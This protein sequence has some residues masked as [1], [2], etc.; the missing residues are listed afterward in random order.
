MFSSD[1]HM[2]KKYM[3]T[4][5]FPRTVYIR[6]CKLVQNLSFNTAISIWIL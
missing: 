5:E 1:P 3:M 2:L 6:N 4:A